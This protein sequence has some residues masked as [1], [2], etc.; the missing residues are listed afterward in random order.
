[1]R[2]RVAG[3]VVTHDALVLHNITCPRRMEHDAL[4]RTEHMAQMQQ[5]RHARVRE[6]CV[7]PWLAWHDSYRM[8]HCAQ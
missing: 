6:E 1:M 4:R 8:E 2:A 5:V 3:L 7:A